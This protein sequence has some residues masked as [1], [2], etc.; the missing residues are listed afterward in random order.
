M[1]AG[2]G[3]PPV[4]ALLSDFGVSDHY[5]GVM[6]GAVLT[7]CPEATLVDVTHGIPPQ[8]VEYGAA[9]LAES[10][11]FF[12][13][14]TIFVAVVDPGVGTER[15]ALAALA[16][17]YRFVAPDNGL[18]DRVFAGCGP[19]QVVALTESQYG[20]SVMSK[21]FEG[22]DRFA[23]V[24]GHLA[25]GVPLASLGR[26]VREWRRLPVHGPTCAG[27]EIRGRV[28]RIDHFGNVI[29]DITRDLV[30]QFRA[31]SDVEVHVGGRTIRGI[32]QTYGLGAAGRPC[33][34]FDSSDHLEV[35]VP[36]GNAAEALGVVRGDTVIVS[37]SVEAPC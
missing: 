15:A 11:R 10:F 23:P 30:E 33:A 18:L 6:R 13:T 20:R 31:G 37:R 9:V 35:A 29:T 25:R 4:V 7:V 24:A 1:T 36:L 17:G 32:V 27:Q 5:V 3:S 8:D 34:L 26:T 2:N 22:R 16:G 12:P 19:S 21:T 28:A 14:G